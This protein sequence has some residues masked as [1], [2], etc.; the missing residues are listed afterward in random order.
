M[1]HSFL[2]LNAIFFPA[3][4]AQQHHYIYEIKNHDKMVYLAVKI[5]G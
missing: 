5:C 3:Q 2:F 4:Y 1:N